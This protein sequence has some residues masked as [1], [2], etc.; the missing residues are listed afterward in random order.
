MKKIGKK[1][2]PS[3]VSFMLGNNDHQQDDSLS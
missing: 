1:S 2:C 3:T